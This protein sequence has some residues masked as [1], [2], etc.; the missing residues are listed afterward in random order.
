VLS[1]ILA[2][3]SHWPGA[4]RFQGFLHMSSSTDRI[5]HVMP[6]IKELYKIQIGPRT[7]LAVPTSKEALDALCSRAWARATSVEP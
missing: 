7:L 4:I 3:A 2:P 5:A 1:T 6:T